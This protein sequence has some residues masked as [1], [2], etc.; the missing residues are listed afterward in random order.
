[1]KTIFDEVQLQKYLLETLEAYGIVITGDHFVYASGKHGDAY[2][3]KDA[4]Y[5][6]PELVGQ[7]TTL[8]GF[9][10]RSLDLK[11]SV[12][13]GPA[14]GGIPLAQLFAQKWLALFGEKKFVVIVE[15]EGAENYIVKRGY[16]RIVDGQE[17]L[18]VEDILTTGKS[19]SLSID[20]LR[21]CHARV[22]QVI[23]IWQRGEAIDTRGVP[24]IP[25]MK[26]IFPM[27]EPEH[28]PLCANQIPL[29]TQL[30]K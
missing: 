2:V 3:N 27:Y 29:N 11:F 20:A 14:L 4:I 16:D 13:A 28:C 23:N 19:V 18:L 7:I 25:L 9:V 5:A 26:K 1:M 10:V 12:V 15:K 21:R 22:C 30:G 24:Y 6:H 17:V 8:M